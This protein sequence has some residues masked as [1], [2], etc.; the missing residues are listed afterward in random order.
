MNLHLSNERLLVGVV[1]YLFLIGLACGSGYWMA[2]SLPVR[3]K[4]E[5]FLIA[6]LAGSLV[7]LATYG[8]EKLMQEQVHLYQII[9]PLAWFLL[10]GLAGEIT[11]QAV[12]R[13]K[14][15]QQ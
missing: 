2:R 12:A 13:R 6:L 4:G 10:W 11:V 3:F 14:R 5:K 1:G 8:L 7:A 15:D 9:S